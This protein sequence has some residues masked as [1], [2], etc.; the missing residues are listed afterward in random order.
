MLIPQEIELSKKETVAT[1]LGKR[2]A[3]N[4]KKNLDNLISHI[5]RYYWE[6]PEDDILHLNKEKLRDCYSKVLDVYIKDPTKEV[7]KE[8]CGEYRETVKEYSKFIKR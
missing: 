2:S 6:N 4:A 1:Y 7:S 8:L 3:Q 5:R